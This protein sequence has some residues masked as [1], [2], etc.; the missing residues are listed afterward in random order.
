MADMVDAEV[1]ALGKRKI[2]EKTAAKF[3]Y[4]VG[5]YNGKSVQIA[6]Y[7]DASG[8]LVAQKVRFPNKEFTVLGKMKE[9]Q[10]FGQKA[11]GTQGRRIV[12]T[13][14]EI[15]A[16]AVAQSFGLSWP[17]VSIPNGAQGAKASIAKHLEWLCGFEEVVLMFDQD[18]IGREAAEES[19]QLFPPG[20]CKIASLPLKDA[21]EMVEQG[22]EDEVQRAV[23][24]AS[25]YRPDG[26]VRVSDLAERA[27]RPVEWGLPWFDERL[28][29]LTYG[30]R[31]GEVYALGAGTGIGKTE[32]YLQQLTYD[33]DVLGEKVAGFFLEQDPGETLKRIAGK[34]DGCMYHLP[35][36]KWEQSALDAAIDRLSAKDDLVLYDSFG[37]AEWPTVASRIRFLHHS[38]GIRIFYIDHLTAFAAEAEDE[39]KEL[40]RTMAQMAKLAKELGIV[41]HLISHLATPEGKPHEEGGRVMIRHFKGSRAIGFWCHFMFGL[42]REQQAENAADRQLTCFRVLKDR[43]TGRSTGSTIFYTWDTERGLL[44]PSDG[45]TSPEDEDFSDEQSDF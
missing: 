4:G 20:K 3:G 29:E 22:R 10:L 25:P 37:S 35:D 1:R 5:S 2:E 23:W 31:P 39:R 44:V 42:E 24:N 13:E 14:G 33:I 36:Q 34:I 11:W 40:E 6:P 26:L 12:V 18:D 32:L 8:H 28:T 30:R 15:D 43:Y 16:M 45:P 19:A 17:V 27:K 21:G 9:A 7:Y 38:E 41:I